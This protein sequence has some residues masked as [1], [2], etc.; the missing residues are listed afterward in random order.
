MDVVKKKVYDINYSFYLDLLM[1]S[2]SFYRQGIIFNGK[3]IIQWKIW[4]ALFGKKNSEVF[5]I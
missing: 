2:V 3:F 4:D 1:K 5:W